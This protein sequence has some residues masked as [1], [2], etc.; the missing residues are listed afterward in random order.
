VIVGLVGCATT[1]F[2]VPVFDATPHPNGISQVPVIV[3][4]TPGFQQEVSIT[5]SKVQVVGVQV[6][7]PSTLFPS[8]VTPIVI[9]TE[10]WL[11]PE[12][13]P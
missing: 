11:L 5:P 6:A 4:A 12:A 10:Q 9:G 13:S 1:K 7:V 2:E 8:T 3:C